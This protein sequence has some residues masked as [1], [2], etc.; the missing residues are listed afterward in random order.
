MR[1]FVLSIALI[2]V[3]CARSALA[4]TPYLVKDIN[5][6]PTPVGSNPHA[7]VRFGSLA[8]F[9]AS[10][11]TTT[12]E[13]W[14]TDGTPAGT[15]K[16]AGTSSSAVVW[17]GKVWFTSGG[18]WSTDGTVAGTQQL[19]LPA[20]LTP[21]FLMA[22]P[23]HL[24]FFDAGHLWRT[25]GTTGGTA[26]LSTA[27]LAPAVPSAIAGSRLC[28]LA[29]SNGD[30]LE[31]WTVDGAGNLSQVQEFAS[32]DVNRLLAA[33]SQVYFQKS[34]GAAGVEVW[35]SDGTP[36]G[37]VRVQS[38][39][40]ILMPAFADLV[41]D[42]AFVYVSGDDGTGRKL[43]RTDGTH[44]G[45]VV[46]SDYVRYYGGS[47]GTP[48]VRLPNGNLLLWS[49]SFDSSLDVLVFDGT[50][51]TYLRGTGPAAEGRFRAY[52][53]DN[54][55]FFATDDF[56]W[57]SDGTSAGTSWVGSPGSFPEV[58]PTW[59]GTSLGASV[60][61]GS[62]GENRGTE[63]WKL[64]GTAS[65]VLVKDIAESTYGS[66]PAE[67]I[68]LR[69][70]VIFHAVA[71]EDYPQQPFANDL[72]FSDGTTAGTQ[73]LV[74]NV[75]PNPNVV[76][77]GSWAFFK[78]LTFED[79]EE[80]WITDGT[81]AGTH[82]IV[83]LAPGKHYGTQ[84]GLSS[85]PARPTCVDGLL[86]FFAEDNAGLHLWRT[87]GTA[88]GTTVVDADPEW[89]GIGTV[90]RRGSDLFFATT[91]SSATPHARLWRSGTT[92]GTTV[93]V[94]DFPASSIIEEL[95]VA[96]SNVYV[97]TKESA[98]AQTLWRSDGTE[99]GTVALRTGQSFD[100][101]ADFYGRL[102]YS[103]KD[104]AGVSQGFCT[105]DGTNGGTCFVPAA[106]TPGATFS[107]TPFNGFLSYNYPDLRRT[108][109]A[110]EVL[111]GVTAV[112]KIVATGGGRLFLNSAYLSGGQPQ[113]LESDGTA[114]GTALV[115]PLP[116]DEAVASGGRLFLSQDE[117]YALDFNV[118]ATGFSPSTVALPGGQTITIS[119]RGFSGPVTI[120]IG[121]VQAAIGSVSPTV[122]TFTAPPLAEGF[123]PIELILGDGRRMTLETLLAYTCTHPT[124]VITAATTSVCSAV[125]VPL[126]GSGGV[127]CS[128][129]P[130]SY[131]DDASSCTPTAMIE[132]A[133]TY[134]LVVYNE[135]G[136]PST[137]APTV[138]LSFA[139]PA[140]V[141]SITPAV[142]SPG[143]IVT[144][145]GSRLQCAKAVVLEA[146]DSTWTRN[147]PFNIVDATTIQF[148]QPGD[149][150]RSVRPRVGDGPGV[151]GP[152]YLRSSRRDFDA[153]VIGDVFWRNTS[154]G[155]NS[156]W[157][158]APS[159]F[160][161]EVVLTVPTSWSPVAIADFNGDARA[162]VFWTNPA[163]GETS[164]W[165]MNG[166]A[167]T[168]AVRSTT[169]PVAW[170]PIGSADFNGDGKA[171]LFWHNPT[172]G[173]TSVWL[174]NGTTFTGMRSLTV[175]TAWKPVAFGDF[176]T[177]AKGDVF[178][179]NPSTGETSIWLMNG[180]MPSTTVRSDT[181]AGP[182]AVAGSGDFDADG[183][184]DLFWWNSATSET[185]VWY[186]DGAVIRAKKT[187]PA[188]SAGWRPIQ[189]SHFAT[190]DT[191]DVFWHN[192][193]TGQTSVWQINA[194]LASFQT[195]SPLKVADPNWKP[196]ALP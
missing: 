59:Q 43:W 29:D 33:G 188:M 91:T 56:L 100:L 24:Y 26:Q 184:E 145:H 92:P 183:K 76:A 132:Q 61:Y 117:L 134:S 101:H 141:D 53:A 163:T 49:A 115:S 10:T 162:D 144:I 122:I 1:Q 161:G 112:D 32:P 8:V 128:W 45:T 179:R 171:D 78:G 87:D 103:W 81:P 190:D 118:A 35:R 136:C 60:V 99:A 126:Q 143:T 54:V 15:Y 124:A 22:G 177:D 119:G 195:W 146:A 85:S 40:P 138:T 140:I 98:T 86:L 106:G 69:G 191:A 182:W 135:N 96:G 173:E 72:W 25:D 130:T 150:P 80:P 105:T 41:T 114:A 71:T 187:M 176:N 67:F 47:M 94:K 133:I 116:V 165:L 17:N 18:L 108:D 107:M 7:F 174:M 75:G 14:R 11:P 68:A 180:G 160:R 95:R 139:P 9:L 44:A 175:P 19:T 77:C 36:A 90:A 88:A 111:T 149:A 57:R 127:R 58:P 23:A 97:V 110:A 2:A 3:L 147:V 102:T 181:L 157:S 73:K 82:M 170:K 169:V 84:L 48:F 137:N 79:G 55:A 193:T 52:L 159:S 104:S 46:V 158:M 13:L 20:G 121:G 34:A 21:S 178:W 74:T 63:L 83:D 64:A 70:G 93:M 142:A 109:G 4:A 66:K 62:P 154:T 185:L 129:F 155:Q 42:G 152:Y 38:T 167:I 30:G 168:T 166:P 39:A 186:L 16:L 125:R 50:T 120:L 51:T 153:G 148:R 196:V 192:A 113:F 65:P 164:I 189:V 123:Y 6:R 172:T 194:T 156:L 12:D 31:L 37:T 5:A 89:P 27:V 151:A 28:F 131:L